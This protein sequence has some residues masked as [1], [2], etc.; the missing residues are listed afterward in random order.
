MNTGIRGGSLRGVTK[1]EALLDSF[2]P[3]VSTVKAI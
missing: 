3:R 2:K 1:F